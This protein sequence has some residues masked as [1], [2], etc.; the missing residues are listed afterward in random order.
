MSGQLLLGCFCG[1]AGGALWCRWM[2]K[3]PT[4]DVLAVVLALNALIDVALYL[5]SNHLSLGVH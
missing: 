2:G 5:V 3:A 1:Y 4:W